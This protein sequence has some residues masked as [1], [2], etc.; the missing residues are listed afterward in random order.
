MVLLVWL[1]VGFGAARNETMKSDNYRMT[2]NTLV[3]C[4]VRHQIAISE[5]FKIINL[6]KKKHRIR[7]AFSAF[8]AKEMSKDDKCKVCKNC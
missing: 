3:T 4:V 1:K 8:I 7:Q 5:V 2:K 6:V